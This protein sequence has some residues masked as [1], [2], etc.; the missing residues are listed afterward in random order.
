M[1]DDKVMKRTNERKATEEI[2]DKEY[3]RFI[4]FQSAVSIS[5]KHY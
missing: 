2:E 4:S 5:A 1:E 3:K